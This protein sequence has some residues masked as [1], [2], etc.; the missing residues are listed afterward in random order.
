MNVS[1]RPYQASDRPTIRQICADTADRGKPVEN[2]FSDRE[3]FS[4]LVTAYYTDLEP[5]SLWIAEADGQVIGYLSGCLDSR[6]YLWLM[7]CAITPKVILRALLRGV[8]L[9]RQTYRFILAMLK[10]CTLGGLNR[11]ELSFDKYPAH[12]HI[13]IKDG[14]RGKQIGQLLMEKF[15]TQAK[16]RCVSG[17]YLTVHQD[18][19]P[20]R[21]FFEK[22][23]F[24]FL[25]RYPMMMPEN[26]GF[27]I[28]Y[29]A[30][31]VKDL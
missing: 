16:S 1:I 22:M 31:Y 10:S 23:G 15:F 2:F 21:E 14:F 11:P 3:V 6:R 29:S 28:N 9:R 7:A 18:N 8:F 5:K 4:D 13:D 30:L 27:K 25:H 19:T 17:M 12:L 24:R 20:A 26:G